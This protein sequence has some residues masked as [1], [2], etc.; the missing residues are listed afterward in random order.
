VVPLPPEPEPEPAP[1]APTPAPEPVVDR[2][3]ISTDGGSVVVEREGAVL[4][5]GALE[6]AAGVRGDIV[7]GEGPEVK[8]LFTDGS[9]RWWARAWI[10]EA[11]VLRT[12][13]ARETV[14]PPAEPVLVWAEIPGVAAVHLK[15]LDGLVWIVEVAP[16]PG[17]GPW[18]T[19]DGDTSVRIEFEGNGELWVL[20]GALGPDGVPVYDYV[21]VA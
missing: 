16:Q 15:A 18:I 1:P 5:A 13:T 8:V 7:I 4:F 21:R 12:D 14:E 19:R 3:V 9:T 10:D 6:P 11:G 20:E 2:V 17:Y